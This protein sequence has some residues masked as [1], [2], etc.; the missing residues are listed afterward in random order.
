MDAS[1][2]RFAQTRRCLRRHL[3]GAEYQRAG[4]TGM[5]NSKAQCAKIAGQGFGRV[6][7]RAAPG[8]TSPRAF[9][10]KSGAVRK[11]AAERQTVSELNQQLHVLEQT[12]KG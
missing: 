11:I 1:Q 4:G 8:K 12:L 7:Q 6:T 2:A 9:T 5:R 10:G 3:S